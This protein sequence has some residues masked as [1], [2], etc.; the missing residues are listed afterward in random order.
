ME[1]LSRLFTMKSIALLAFVVPLLIVAVIQY[2]YY[3]KG[4]A[5]E[6]YW[7][8]RLEFFAKNHP[9][10]VSQTKEAYR[11][12]RPEGSKQELFSVRQTSIECKRALTEYSGSHPLYTA[13]FV[14]P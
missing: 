4:G 12:Q 13:S 14:S 2:D 10:C 9:T 11:G 1:V 3:F 8:D 7:N 5:H 6:P